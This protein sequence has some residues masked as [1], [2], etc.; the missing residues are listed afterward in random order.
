MALT[1]TLF[2]WSR[3]CLDLITFTPI[4]LRMSG[5][6]NL[7]ML[8]CF[9]ISMGFH[10]NVYN[11]VNGYIHSTYQWPLKGVTLGFIQALWHFPL[12]NDESTRSSLYFISMKYILMMKVTCKVGVINHYKRQITKKWM[13][14]VSWVI[15]ILEWVMQQIT[16]KLRQYLMYLVNVVSFHPIIDAF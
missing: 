3:A 11:A 9:E 1:S 12:M 5:E 13:M 2:Y 7:N 14:D 16:C 15:Y 4:L 10:A 8:V 6:N